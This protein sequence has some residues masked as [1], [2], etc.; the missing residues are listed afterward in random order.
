M[1]DKLSVIIA[2]YNPDASRLRQ[3]LEGLQQ[4]SLSLAQWELIVV[5]NNS[6]QPLTID[7]S[8]HPQAVIVHEARQ[9]LTYAR[10]KGFATAKNELIVLVDDDN[11][12]DADYLHHVLE[13]FEKRTALGAIGGKS[14]PI[15]ETEPPQWLK[16]F[17]GSLALRDLGDEAKIQAW[18]NSYPQYAPIGAGM[19]IRKAALAS[20]I[21]KAEDG[22]SM[23]ADRSG[24]SLA[25][26]GDND[27]VLEVLKSGWQVGYFPQLLLQHIIPQGRM[28]A[29]YLAKLENSTNNSW[30]KL[31][32]S[33]GICPW[34][35]I[36]AYTLPLR[37]AK[38]WLSLKAALSK[39]NYIK[40]RGYCGTMDA[41]A[42]YK[43]Y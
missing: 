1:P 31:L 13:I 26:G 3:T 9:G 34:P 8:W 14:L 12:I 19:G 11:V 42:V 25:S 20:Y 4:Q 15:F 23:I 41:L 22:Q 32:Q 16:A 35:S 40:W 38:A 28:Q 39:S 17:Y 2:T 43:K 21:K 27:I 37:K 36:P 5:D 18:E 29:G 7:L 6:T 33:H 10:L 30:I 24:S